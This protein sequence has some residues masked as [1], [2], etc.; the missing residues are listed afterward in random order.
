MNM[1]QYPIAKPYL[2]KAEE[3]GVL[4][5]LR[6][7]VLSIGPRLVE[8]EKAFAQ[9]IGTKFAC[10]VSSGT[11]G[12]H[13]AMIA[14]GIK[15]GDEV[16]TSP[17]SFIASANCI[18][19][20][21]AKPVF[22]DIDPLTYNLD[23]S[24]IETAITK[25]T[26]AILVVHIFGQPADM[27]VITRI[28]KQHGLK[29]IEDA[30]ESINAEQ[31]GKKVGT[32][33]EAAVFAF[34]PNKQITT[35]EGGMLVTNNRQI[36]ALCLSLRNQGRAANMQWLDYQVMGYNYR[37]TEISAALGISQ[38]AKLDQMIKQRQTIAG[39]YS[40]YLEPYRDL[41][42]AP[43]TAAG[44]THTWFVYVVTL[45]H[46]GINRDKIIAALAQHGVSSKSYLPSIHLFSFYKKR[47]GYKSG[48]FPVAEKISR[49]ALALPFYLSLKKKDIRHIVKV[50]IR[51]IKS[52][53]KSV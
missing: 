39:W 49:S 34:Y 21:G 7:G 53:G 44:N 30:C 9:I 43:R 48:D 31:R 47:F 35:G 37:M 25:K 8:F 1:K 3:K 15:S 50:L 22:V 17:F 12:L 20:V 16:I 42:Q 10:A 36:H 13:L 28:A 45:K 18:L 41:L 32:F 4:A 5:V 26:K 27:T 52:Y 46:P 14:A 11:A 19:Y 38:L 33:G 51:T 23:P 40:W 2:T 24:K 29:I 6:S